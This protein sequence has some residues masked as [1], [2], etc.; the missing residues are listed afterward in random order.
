VQAQ[1][2]ADNARTL[3]MPSQAFAMG[4]TVTID[5][6]FYVSKNEIDAN[7]TE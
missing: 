4:A 1:D 5:D 6:E 3:R 7:M 2:V